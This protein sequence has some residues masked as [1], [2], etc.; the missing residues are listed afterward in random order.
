MRR[1]SHEILSRQDVQVLLVIPRIEILFALGRNA[2]QYGIQ[3][4]C[5]VKRVAGA[6]GDLQIHEARDMALG[7]NDRRMRGRG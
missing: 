7:G 6:R 5:F 1:R 3:N 2:E 4:R